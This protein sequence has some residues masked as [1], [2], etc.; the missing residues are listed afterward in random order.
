VQALVEVAWLCTAWR[1]RAVEALDALLDA[2]EAQG[3]R[4]QP[5]SEP[6]DVGG[7]GQVERA[8]GDLLGLHL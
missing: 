4:A 3:H 7:G 6:F 2:L 5:A 8:H 1:A